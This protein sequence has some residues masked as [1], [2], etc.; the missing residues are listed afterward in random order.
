MA[1]DF[2]KFPGG[3][4]SRVNRAGYG[5]RDGR[6]SAEDLQVIEEWRA[7]HRSVLNTFQAILRN[8]TRGTSIAVAQRHKRKKTIFDKL[9]RLPK[10]ELSRMDDV[11]GCRLIFQT[12][13][14]LVSFR[15]K[16]HKARFNHKRRNEK[17]KYD[18]ILKPKSTGYRGIHDVY[19]YDVRSS[20][21]KDLTGLYVEIQYRTL[22]QHAWATAVEVIGFVTESQPKFQKGDQRYQQAMA[23]ASEILARAHEGMFGPLPDLSDSDLVGK[24]L[25]LDQSL[26]LMKTLHGLNSVDK[27]VSEKRN[28]ILVF[29][30]EGKLEIRDF[31]DAPD[32]LKVLFDLEKRHPEYDIVLVRADTSDDVRIAFKNYFSDARDFIRLIEDGCRKIQSKGAKV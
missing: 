2:N 25:A 30:L 8:R 15:E 11:A 9:I 14:E 26:N 12:V 6:Q 5:I 24:F 22:V 18:Y 23:L 13:D 31:R 16:F 20:V 27:I 29:D 7:A 3:S 4:R 19:N 1:E 21:G 17:D 10:M 32:A 28:A